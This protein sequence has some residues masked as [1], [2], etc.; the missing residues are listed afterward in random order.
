VLPERHP[1]L[2]AHLRRQTAVQLPKASPAQL[3]LRGTADML[4]AWQAP[5][6]SSACTLWP[7]A[8]RWLQV[9]GEG[10]QA[11]FDNRQVHALG[12]A[13][14][15][16]LEAHAAA[17]APS[18]ESWA[19]AV[20][21]VLSSPIGQGALQLAAQLA[22]TPQA[23]NELVLLAQHLLGPQRSATLL[24]TADLSQAAADLP[25]LAP[26][27][28]H[29]AAWLQP[30]TGLVSRVRAL[31]QTL[32]ACDTQGGMSTL[33]HG[34]VRDMGGQ[35]PYAALVDIFSRVNRQVP[36]ADTPLGADDF[37]T[38]LATCD[39]LIHSGEHGFARLVQLV[40]GRRGRPEGP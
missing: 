26:L 29:L 17:D 35:T 3:W 23:Y 2:T 5:P 39:D 18:P 25:S 6:Q 32:A 11:H 31:T 1:Q 14:L 9:T 34:A 36:G 30:E 28:Q 10:P 33:V 19:D 20:H 4:A 12:H 8:Q 40:Q 7:V 21:A 16:A 13:V 24:A 22:A 15:R 37:A 27:L 38:L